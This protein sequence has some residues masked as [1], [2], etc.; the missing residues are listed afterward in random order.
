MKTIS[1]RGL[2]SAILATIKKAAKERAISMN[3]FIVDALEKSVG[4]K[5]KSLSEHH[6][7]DEFFGSWNEEEYARITKSV[8]AHRQIDKELWP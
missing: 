2:D 3:R 5:H 4:V 1:V 6:D 8:G 7:L